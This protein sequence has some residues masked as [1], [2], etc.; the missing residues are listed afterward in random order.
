MGEIQKFDLLQLNGGVN[1]GEDPVH[2]DDIQL[3]ESFNMYPD[4]KSCKR[5]KGLTKLTETPNSEDITALFAHKTSVGLWTLIAAGRTKF[6]KKSG[7]GFADIAHVEGPGTVFTDDGHP[8][9]ISSIRTWS[10]RRG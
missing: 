5:R 9:V 2:I 10:M 4:G 3:Q 7:T 1:Q 8:W 6:S